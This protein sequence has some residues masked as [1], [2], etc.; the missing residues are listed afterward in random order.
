M[1]IGFN[2]LIAYL[3]FVFQ[4]LIAPLGSVMIIEIATKYGVDTSIIGYIFALGIV[5]GGISALASGFLIEKFGKRKVVFAGIFIATLAGATITSSNYLAMFA[6][7]MFLSGVSSWFMVAVGNYII[8][9]Y[10]QGEKRSSQLNLLNFFYSIGALITPTLAGFMLERDVPWEVAFLTPFILLVLL[11]ILSYSPV[12]GTSKS[13]GSLERKLSQTVSEEKWNVNIYVTGIALGI[14]CMLE[15]S[16]TS[17]IVVHLREN[18]TVDIVAASLVLTIF[19]I[20]Q[21][22]GRFASGFIVKHIKLNIYILACSSLGLVAASL[23]VFSKSYIVVLC[24][25]ILMGLGIA[26]LY[27]SILSYGTLQV[28]RASPRIMTF[29]LTSGIV[30]SVVGMLITSFLKQNFGVLACIITTAISL[31]FVIICIGVT[32]LGVQRNGLDRKKIL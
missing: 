4:G 29:F 22:T 21:A 18:L 25:T 5:G 19:Y 2:V 3:I 13:K 24:L 30:G 9:K 10:Y 26:S 1:K 14:Y 16:Y 6:L 7:G 23:I 12:F 31:A 8:V 27:P 28:K 20:C 32:M 15:I 11:A 17:W